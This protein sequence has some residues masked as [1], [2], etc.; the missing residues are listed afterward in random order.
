MKTLKFITPNGS[1]SERLRMYL[2]KAGY[3]IDKPDR[4]GYCGRSQNGKIEFIER[5]RRMIPH[6]LA[7]GHF[8]AGIT[9]LDLVLNSG[10]EGLRTVANLCFAKRS[11][12]P[13]RWVLA[14]DPKEM[15]R[16]QENLSSLALRVGCEL[17]GLVRK[18]MPL[19]NFESRPYSLDAVV[20][21]EGNEE[22]AIQDGL[23]DAILVVTETGKT[24]E[25]IGLA[26]PSGYEQLL[27][28]MPQIIAQPK[29]PL[30]M[31]DALQ[32]LRFALESVI[33]AATRVMMKADL[34]KE[35]L[36]ELQL[37]SE[38]SPTV[39]PLD[40]KGWI[41]VEICIPRTDIGSVGL[42]LE[43]AGARGIVVQD[44]IAY[45]TGKK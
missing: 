5:D 21:L 45:T 24:L 36:K 38:V 7:T 30:D 19:C 26:V 14:V 39:S 15:Q 32:E 40:R 29:L 11:D 9:G 31:E 10:V 12:H 20:Q 22:M 25:D 3:D 1:L 8:A 34:C 16:R 2:A 17:P 41:A 35:A 28:S 43:N 42:K 4:R 13:T 6:L 33:S 44:V 27:I 37:P 18:I 23:C